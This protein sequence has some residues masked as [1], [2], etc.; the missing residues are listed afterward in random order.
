LNTLLIVGITLFAGLYSSKLTSKLKLPQVVGHIGVGIILG[1]SGIKLYNVDISP[2]FNIISDLAL[3]II[4]FIIGGEL[5]WARL[6]KVGISII[7]I[8]FFEA[9][10]S[11]FLVSVVLYLV[12]KNIAISL[13][14]GALSSATD[15]GGTV[16]VVQEYRARGPVTTTLF[17][18]VGADD[19]FAVIIYAF[20]YCVAKF[21]VVTSGVEIH[22]FH[23]IMETFREMG[24]SILWGAGLGYFFVKALPKIRH[25]DAKQLFTF[26][27]V[28]VCIGFSVMFHL[29]IILSSMS[30][31]IMISNLKPHQSR[32]FFISLY[33]LTP[34]IYIMFFVL[35]GA[36]LQ[37]S[38]LANMGVIGLIYIVFRGLGKFIG[39][40]IGGALSNSPETVKKYLGLCLM[41]QAGV[42]VGLAIAAQNDLARLSLEGKDIGI[43]IVNVITATTIFFQIIG[44]IL[45]KIAL[46]K[47]GEIKD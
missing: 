41:P 4:G 47:A 31:G 26:S 45:A 29:S 20:A 36:K 39:P 11:F 23:M 38:L 12:T 17:G 7:T 1:L 28:M 25:D 16:N 8:T 22:P 37:I 44:P 30:M 9:F 18:V 3:G 10:L 27:L 35:V 21:F 6:K 43:L 5:R 14:I 13:I 19:A 2:N 42:A 40:W 46:Q 24:G 33:R 32:S 15:P 34:S